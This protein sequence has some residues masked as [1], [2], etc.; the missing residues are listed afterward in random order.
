MLRVLHRLVPLALLVLALGLKLEEPP[1]LAELRLT[2]FDTYQRLWPREYQPAPV[3]VVDIDEKSLSE[4]GQWPWSRRTLAEL[5]QRLSDYGAAVVAFDLIFAEPDRT[6]PAAMAEQ[7]EDEIDSPE[8]T[9]ELRR[10]PDHDALFSR[11]LSRMTAVTGY[12]LTTD[13]N[14][15]RPTEKWGTGFAGDSPLPFLTT[16]RGAVT[17]L[18]ELVGAAAGNGHLNA[19]PDIDGVI[20]RVMLLSRIDDTVYPSLTMEALRTVQGASTY[21]VKSSNA[22]GVE[23]LGASTGI[24]SMK[25]G[26]L[27]VPTDPEGGYWIHYTGHRNERFVS[28]SDVLAG[29]VAPEKLQGNIVVIGSS[30]AGLKDQRPTPLDPAAPG[31]EIHAEALEQMI[32][33]ISLLRPDW[34]IGA[35][36]A[37]ILVLGLLLILIQPRLGAFYSAILGATAV[38]AAMAGSVYAF[39]YES[40]LFDPV[41]PSVSV[42]A[43]FLSAAFISFLRTE[44]SRNQIRSAFGHYLAPELVRQLADNPGTLTLGGETRNISILFAD[45]RGFTTI[46]EG[47]TPEEITTLINRFLTPMSDAV[48]THKGT[49]DKYVGDQIM[50]FWNAPLDDPDH[51][52]NACQAALDMRHALDA[53]NDERR[54]EVEEGETFLP[55]RMGVGINSGPTLVGNM[56]SQQR[57]NYS[58]L[59]DPVNEASRIEG[60][61]KTYGVDILVSEV[62]LAAANGVDPDSD[63]PADARFAALEVDRVRLVGLQRPS[64]L[65]ALIGGAETANDPAF[66]EWRALH[67]SMLAAYRNQDWDHAERLLAQCRG[68]DTPVNLW[69][70]YELYEER[71]AHYREEAPDADWGGVA[72]AER[73]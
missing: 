48:L 2:V 17:S 31:V 67:D 72:T 20:R 47:L 13:A 56:G 6:S 71:I 41:V 68:L 25:V 11:A 16:Y 35:E 29:A 30:A 10:L 51:A 65:Y 15:A 58:A 26:A 49:I 42:L 4:V 55:L 14:E 39:L 5:L 27:E 9:E 66:Q 54:T 73:K 70:V 7:L 36:F 21:L 12:V 18:P 28:A 38:V 1:Q 8:L 34:A 62:S 46:C 44:Q 23:S 57:F 52:A 19:L 24:V 33:G 32:L 59:G 53:L 69:G 43:V 64:R 45:I 37:F 63:T 50:A 61:T 40:M 60:Q 3:R 22:S